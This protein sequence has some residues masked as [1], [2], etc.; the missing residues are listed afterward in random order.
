MRSVNLL[1]RDLGLLQVFCIASGAMISS[2]LFIQ[3]LRGA[4]EID[5]GFE[6]PGSL[7]TLSVDPGLQGYEVAQARDFFDRL[8]EEVGALPAVTSVGMVNYLPLGL[9]S[10]DRS[11]DIP[12][13][14]FSEEELR[15][16][17]YTYIT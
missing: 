17:P 10:S 4:T 12:G 1:R 2:G 11:V 3:S 15:S 14:E 8:Q 13:Y 9:S 7:A 5:P 6:D 16:I